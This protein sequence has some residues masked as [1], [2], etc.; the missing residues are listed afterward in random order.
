MSECDKNLSRPA[1]K[2]IKALFAVCRNRCAFPKCNV[3]AYDPA[4]QSVLVEICHIEGHKPD[5]SRYRADQ[6]ADERHGFGN[7]VL[8]CG[9][10]HKIIDDDEESYTVER[11][12]RI[13]ANH[14][15]AVT[16]ESLSQGA[17][18]AANKLLANFSAGIIYG[19]TVVVSQHQ[20]GGQTA[21][22]IIN[23]ALPPRRLSNAVAQDLVNKL[24]NFP[25]REC[26]VLRVQGDGEV[27]LLAKQIRDVLQQAGWTAQDIVALAS[28][29]RGLH[30]GLR[31]LPNQQSVPE[32]V[33][34]LVLCFC[35]AKLMPQPSIESD[36]RSHILK[37]LVGHQV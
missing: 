16:D 6:P 32:D 9:V 37:I 28:D 27:A 21:H 5:S 25:P 10:H 26:Q 19:S 36:P 31:Q 23:N 20:M 13:K 29:A 34:I 1:T 18:E 2:T 14:E 22:T 30:V 35:D 24:K 15:T 12:K 8:M 3:F 33:A 17:E 7:L 4:T 11:L